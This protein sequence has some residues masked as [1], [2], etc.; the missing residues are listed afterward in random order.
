M[1]GKKNP[2]SI[3]VAEDDKLIA[4][5]FKFSLTKA[6][7]EVT[8]AYDGE[9]ATEMIQ[10]NKPDVVLLDMMMPKKTGLEVLKDIRNDKK[11]KKTPV[12]IISNVEDEKSI[13][14]A[15]ELEVDEYLLK[16]SVTTKDIIHK[17]KKH[18]QGL[19]RAEITYRI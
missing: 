13:Q 11:L 1:F 5:A 2:L 10:K 12:L 14:K 3:L 16:T 19:N 6:G 7:F 17:I 4:R 18:C 9:E 15:N 8:N